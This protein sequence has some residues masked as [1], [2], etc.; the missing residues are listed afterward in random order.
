MSEEL[1]ELDHELLG[2]N[3]ATKKNSKASQ[4]ETFLNVDAPTKLNGIALNME[5]GEENSDASSEEAATGAAVEKLSLSPK[6]L[7]AET[8][9]VE[10]LSPKK[11]RAPAKKKAEVTDAVEKAPKTK[12]VP[13]AK[14]ASVAVEAEAN[15]NEGSPKATKSK[16]K[17]QSLS[18]KEPTAPKS[19][20]AIKPKVEED[21]EN[22][23]NGDK[24]KTAPVVKQESPLASP[25]A[26]EPVTVKRK[27]NPNAGEEDAAIANG[28]KANGKAT[29]PTPKKPR[30]GGNKTARGVEV[31]SSWENASAADKKLVQMKEANIPWSKIRAMWKK[32]TGQDTGNS[33][34]PNR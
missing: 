32:E 11:K 23:A 33:T 10:T 7:E 31:P 17:K 34:L 26:I 24:K 3:D 16:G 21:E 8:S 22:G 2:E 30:V 29:T 19:K 6:K 27:A 14:A 25:E 28:Q 15:E 20:R 5:S 13:K 9:E 4:S 18:D 1:S 12:R